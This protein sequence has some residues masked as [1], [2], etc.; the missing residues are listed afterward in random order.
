MRS[1]AVASNTV[2]AYLDTIAAR[3][4]GR[5]PLQI[6]RH[7]PGGAHRVLLQA[8]PEPDSNTKTTSGALAHDS[9]WTN[10]FVMELSYTNAMT[11]LVAT[12]HCVCVCVSGEAA[13][14][15]YV[16][17]RAARSPTTGPPSNI[18]ALAKL[19]EVTMPRVLLPPKA[20]P[21]PSPSPGRPLS[22][23]CS[24]DRRTSTSRLLDPSPLQNSQS[25]APRR[26]SLALALHPGA[27]TVANIA[28]C[29]RYNAHPDDRSSA[30]VVPVRLTPVHSVYRFAEALGRT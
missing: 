28:T 20:T 9:V 13:Q 14:W 18:W 17:R 29:T 21:G 30:I 8:R 5:H 2:S 3:T 7:S 1:E 24:R 23:G 27:P 10:D 15:G 25:A 6:S 4:R 22:G 11:S 26:A 16:G 12:R 19:G